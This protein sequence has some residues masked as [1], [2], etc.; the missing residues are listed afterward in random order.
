MTSPK[1]LLPLR[2]PELGPSLGKL[3]TGT[4]RSPGGIGLDDFRYR[5][6]TRVMEHAGEARRL[7]ANEERA[8][9]AGTL[10][11][12]AWLAAWEEAIGGTA[13]RLAGLVNARLEAEARAVRMPRRLRSRVVL[14]AN[15]RR[16]LA[17]RLGSSG[18]L[19]IPALDEVDRSAEAALAATALE[20]DVVTAWQEA[21]KTA[22][23]RLE[24]AWLAL[25]DGVEAE[26]QRWNE[27]AGRIGQWRKPLWPVFLVGGVALA[28]AVWF[29]LAYGGLLPAP[30][31]LVRLWERGAP[32]P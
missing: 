25:E 5:L 14:E 2:V 7:S 10:G 15:E 28:A 22:A 11:R 31:W 24:A 6:V 13:D 26:A 17:A 23:R 32:A 20:R 30:D 3:V 4:G 18:A 12:A 29:G 16:A 8:A 1:L 9:A 19:L 27:V 21:L